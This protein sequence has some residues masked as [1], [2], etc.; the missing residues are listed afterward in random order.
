MQKV[1]KLTMDADAE[2]FLLEQCRRRDFDAFSK[3]VDLYQ[4]RVLGFVRRMVGN[5]EEAEDIAQEVFVRAFVHIEKFDGRSSFRTW[6]FRIA[7]NLTVDAVRKKGRSVN[8][9]ALAGDE[10]GEE[11]EVADT[12][13]N[14]E[15]AVL[16]DELIRVVERAIETMSEKLR[17]VLLLHDKEQLPYE[18][19]AEVLEIPVGT[20]K[21]RLF[22]A[23]NHVANVVRRYQNGEGN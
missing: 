16:D 19:L 11:I 17:S 3:M 22:L 6:L 14:P 5:L 4:A 15:S 13:W 2:Q 12:R 20:V 1:G 10:D 18:D 9:I 7:H 8:E 21:S 23:R